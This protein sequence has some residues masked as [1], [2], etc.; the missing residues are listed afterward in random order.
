MSNKI[1]GERVSIVIDEYTLKLE[2]LF[3][4]QCEKEGIPR[5]SR[6]SIVR[7]LYRKYLQDLIIVRGK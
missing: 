4:S 1:E 6:S 2:K 5:P 3:K 7:S